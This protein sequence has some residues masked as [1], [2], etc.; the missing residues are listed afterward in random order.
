[1]GTIMDGEATGPDR[2]PARRSRRAR[3]TEDEVVGFC[4]H[5]ARAGVPSGRAA[6]S[7]RAAPAATARAR[8]TSRRWRRWSWPRAAC[9]WPSTATA[10]RARS[11]GARTCWRRSACASTPVA[12]PALARRGGLDGPLFARASTPPPGTP[13]ARA[14]KLGVR[15]AF[16]LLGPLTNPAA[17]RP[18]SW[19][20]PLEAG[21]L[22]RPLPPA[23]GRAPGVGRPQLWPRRPSLCGGDDGR[24]STRAACG[25]SR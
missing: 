5:D 14:R 17:R 22:R 8:S 23:A 12:R 19:A 20:C 3:E 16:N 21:K 2:G 4:A 7:T 24:R 11:C 25:A 13:W 15:T 9:R 6:R 1:M 10:R 18:R